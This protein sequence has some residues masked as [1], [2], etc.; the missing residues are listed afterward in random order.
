MLSSFQLYGVRQPRVCGART[1]II[2]GA[3][4]LFCLLLLS[5]L[6]YL[7][8]TCHRFI[9][10]I[11]AQLNAA[12]HTAMFWERLKSEI[13]PVIRTRIIPNETKKA[14]DEWKAI[15][16]QRGL[17]AGAAYGGSVLILM[18]SVNRLICY[19]CLSRRFMNIS[20]VLFPIM[21]TALPRRL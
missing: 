10:A 21:A 7:V 18:S 3:E 1:V 13:E 15:A 12:G 9:P 19:C 2:A 16:A 4:A 8:R 5:I 17:V 6:K 11:V 14:R 20:A